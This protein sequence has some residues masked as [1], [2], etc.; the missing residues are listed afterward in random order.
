MC[1]TVETELRLSTHT[2]LQ[3]DSRNP[4]QVPVRDVS[5]ILHLQALV[6][7]GSIILI[8][9]WHCGWVDL[10]RQK[11][12]LSIFYRI[13]IY[14]FLLLLFQLLLPSYFFFRLCWTVF[15][16]NLLCSDCSSTSWLENLWGNEESCL[17]QIQSLYRP[18]PPSISHPRSGKKTQDIFKMN[19]TLYNHILICFRVQLI[20]DFFF[21]S[22][23][24]CRCSGND[25]KYPCVCTT[26]HVQ[27]EPA[28]LC[29][30]HKQQQASEYS[31]YKP[32]CKFHTDSWGWHY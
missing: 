2:H 13:L 3:L 9:G 29:W 31:L 32:Y 26:L 20:K 4:Y 19:T 8:K 30:S 14:L 1:Q 5:P 12:V 17:L 11:F 16:E 6:L 18:I 25:A 27:P 22:L 28:V 23:I 15:G 7:L 24:G 10:P 21:F